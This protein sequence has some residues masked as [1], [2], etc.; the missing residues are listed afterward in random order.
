MLTLTFHN[1]QRILT[2]SEQEFYLELKCLIPQ[3][4]HGCT[5]M[6]YS[7]HFQGC[8]KMQGGMCTM[9]MTQMAM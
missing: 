5:E 9:T 7:I 4:E 8:T 1:Q 3:I 6:N 2:A